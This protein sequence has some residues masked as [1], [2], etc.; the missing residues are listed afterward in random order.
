MDSIKREPGALLNAAK[1]G[2]ERSYPS[3]MDLLAK[4]CG[5][6]CGTRNV[7]GNK[8]V[9]VLVD[10]VLKEIGADVEH[11]ET[12]EFGTHIV[13]RLAPEKPEGKIILHAHLDTAFFGDEVTVEDHPF[14]IEGDYAYG[15]GIA[16][17]KGG[18][19]TILYAVKALKE[20]G[21]LPNKEIVMLFNCDEEIGSPTGTEIF[22]REAPS[23]E[24]IISF[25]PARNKN[26]VLTARRG[27]ATG[28][29]VVHGIAAHAGLDGG[30]GASATRELANLILK[31]T[32]KSDLSIGMNYNVA[33]ISGGSNS[34]TVADHAEAAFCVPID[35]PEVYD[36]VKKDVLEYLPTQGMIE[37]CKIETEISLMCP[38][39]IRCEA[40]IKVYEKL[41]AAAD[42]LGMDLPEEKSF[43]P[44]D[45]C[46]FS[47]INPAVVDGLGPYMYNI[48]TPDEHMIMNTLKGRTALLMV[49]LATC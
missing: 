15:L 35:T 2:A 48:H 25:E 45:C 46:I 9:V 14:R 33:P 24:A 31:L 11:I 6:N 27:L 34:I 13:A 47:E 16:D 18:V 1:A 49:M 37:G 5:I 32:E 7:E 23:A 42:L 19:A 28:K 36:R 4:F 22:R 3:Q 30:L 12:E 44:A 10:A 40:N 43:N 39:M 8:K 26:G 21:L 17:C 29:I 38:P 41:R 20:D